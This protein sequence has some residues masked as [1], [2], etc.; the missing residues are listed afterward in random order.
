MS[1]ELNPNAYFTRE[2]PA[3]WQRVRLGEVCKINPP[4]N[5][6]LK[7]ASDSP[8]SFVP[9]AAVDERLGII[10]RPEIRPFA[11]VRK[12][13]TFFLEGDVLFAK[14]TPCMQNGKHAIARDLRDGIG[15]GTT[16]FHVLRPTSVI[17]P[18]W[19]HYFIRQPAIL[20]AA[21]AYFTGAVGQQ[22]VPETYLA[23]LEISL[24]PLS[25]QKRIAAILNEQMAEVERARAAAETQLESA[26]ALPAAYLR[27]VFNSPEAQKW[28][29]RRLGEILELR[30]D[31]VHPRDNPRG[32][33]MFVGLE[34]IESGTGVRVGA[35]EIEMSELKGRKPR[36]YEGDIVYGYL[37]AYLNKV[38]VAEF[39][40]LCS[41][42][43]YVY[44]VDGS[45]AKTE[46]I[47]WFMRSE[48]Y[49]SRAPIKTTPGQLPRIRTE[50]V[51]S[52]ELN[53][54]PIAEQQRMLAGLSERLREA[55]RT[56]ECFEAQLATINKLPAAL[57]RR[58]FSGGL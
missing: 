16:E 43:Q 12:G 20:R 40:G 38:W 47:A 5:G 58:V 39:N 34:H 26:M 19:V 50:E 4:R 52:V 41:V 21:T 18:E 37:R 10:V 3:G 2:F 31:I 28:Q 48:T 42:D 22:R 53:L 8:T 7:R 44:K 36:F 23:D 51:A 46:F 56:R 13:Y 29:T 45:K 1:A 24:P 55:Q 9:M 33:E 17:I 54:P 15:F 35:V 11:E 14:I 57:L 32:R 30:K 25:E 49:L 6:N 27:A